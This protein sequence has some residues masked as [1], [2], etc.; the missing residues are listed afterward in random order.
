MKRLRYILLLAAFAFVGCAKEEEPLF[1]GTDN[2]LISLSVTANGVTYDASISGDKITLSAPVGADLSGAVATYAL[3][4]HASILPEPTAIKDW[5]SQHVFRI[6]SHAKTPREYTYTV[7]R[8]EVAQSGNVQLL[9]QTDVEKFA[10]L[11]ITVINGNLVIGSD[12]K[13]VKDSIVNLEQLSS[14]KEVRYNIIVNRSFAGGTLRGLERIEK[15]GGLHLGTTA[16][17]VEFPALSGISIDMP[18]LQSVGDMVL[19]SHS[20]KSLSFE[21]LESTAT[22]Y[23]A[24][25]SLVTLNLPTLKE[26][27]GV[28]SFANSAGSANSILAQ[29]SFP[30]L[31]KVGGKLSLQYFSGLTEVGFPKLNYVGGSVDVAL[32]SGTLETLAFPELA[33]VNGAVV[34]E[35]APGLLQLEIPKIKQMTSFIFNKSSYGSYPLERLDLSALETLTDELY[36]RNI[37]IENLTIANLK[38]VGGEVTFWDLKLATKISL[39]SIKKIG[40]RLQLYSTVKLRSLDL[41]TLD[42]LSKLELVGC[43]SLSAIKSPV[44]MGNL[45]LNYASSAECVTPIFD[46]LQSIDG[47]LTLSNDNKIT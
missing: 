34:I 44:A 43:V 25:N 27:V 14:V 6:K 31:E 26:T 36:I 24:S 32:N 37:P 47:T 10:K 45:T 20:I 39:P 38:E 21:K 41:S 11:G 18:M 15:C 33:T 1:G 17:A 28:L 12:S 13:P 3:C 7:S 42:T 23:I 4:E 22:L 16:S 46:G 8:S 35:S 9:T 5:N 2:G 29:L 19:N 40:K 30:K